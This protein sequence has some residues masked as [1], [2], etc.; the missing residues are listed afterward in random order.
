MQCGRQGGTGRPVLRHCVLPAILRPFQV[1]RIAGH[2]PAE[3][4]ERG[5]HRL[6]RLTVKRRRV[7]L[8]PAFLPVAIDE[9]D[10]GA[11][12]PVRRA[13]GDG[14]RMTR[15]DGALLDV[16]LHNQR[17]FLSHHMITPEVTAITT[18][19]P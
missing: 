5:E 2:V 19:A 10:P 6:E 13:A 7:G 14:K 16:Q 3:P 18:R 11:F 12:V 8:A 15:G 9:P 1:E 17:F 4:L